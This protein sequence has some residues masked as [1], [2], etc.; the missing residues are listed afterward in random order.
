MKKVVSLV[1]N[2]ASASAGEREREREKERER[3]RERKNLKKDW[4]SQPALSL[5][6]ALPAGTQPA[7]QQCLMSRSHLIIS[8]LKISIGG[9]INHPLRYNG[10]GQ[11]ILCFEQP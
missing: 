4:P 6:A 5:P 8:V 3:E 9:T 1:F 2:D 7:G 11:L 10:K